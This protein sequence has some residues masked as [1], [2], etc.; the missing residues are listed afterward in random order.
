[1]MNWF[2]IS[3]FI[4]DIYN[5]LLELLMPYISERLGFSIGIGILILNVIY[6]LGNVLQ[7]IWGVFADRTHKLI[8]VFLGIL[9]V[10]IF[11]PLAAV[12]SDTYSLLIFAFFGAVGVSLY[13]PQSMGRTYHKMGIFLMAGTLGYSVAPLVTMGVTK[14]IG[15]SGMPLLATFGIVVAFSMFL[16]PSKKS[17]VP[18]N[19][20]SK[21]SIKAVLKQDGIKD[22]VLM[23][24]A[25]GLVVYSIA[26][27]SPFLW[28]EMGRDI[29]YSGVG[30]FILYIAGAVGEVCIDKIQK[31]IGRRNCF[32][33]GLLSLWGLIMMFI[34]THQ[35]QWMSFV[36]LAGVGFISMGLMPLLI[37][38]GQEILPEAKSSVSGV[39]S[40]FCYAFSCVLAICFGFL[41]DIIGI[42][43]T[44][45]LVSLV[46][47]GCCFFVNGAKKKYFFD[48]VIMQN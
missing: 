34:L 41:C 8:F 1:M 35:Y 13:H 2:Y 10:S 42:I 46:P 40:G 11:F 37:T 44:I 22:L 16:L 39:L 48:I 17:I 18:K 31:K 29:T 27:L 20:S 14:Y 19:K 26:Q 23:S 38:T 21:I 43:P 28:K 45:A 33:F 6:I 9:M 36:V 4:V 7:P 12:A 32:Y 24:I 5:A 30:L 3:H 47:L 25:A 15:L